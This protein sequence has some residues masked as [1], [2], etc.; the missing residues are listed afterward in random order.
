M[1]ARRASPIVPL[2]KV[3]P[4]DTSEYRPVILVVDDES[5][6]ADT[7]TE[8]LCRSGY[9]AMAAYDGSDALETAL[10]TPPEMLITDVML[11]GM[12]GIELAVAIKRIFP[13]CK[14][15]LFSGHA[16]T[17][18]LM[19]EARGKGHHFTLL[20][21][22]IHPKDLLQRVQATLRP[23]DTHIGTAVG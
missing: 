22:P 12:S 1:S 14:I 5:V 11:P 7:V 15:L 6:I 21:K 10:L 3:P 23:H 4:A 19:T 20:A 9:A 18:D 16:A 17:A 2:D 13:D 8:I